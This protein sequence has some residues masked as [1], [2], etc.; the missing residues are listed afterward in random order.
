MNLTIRTA[1]WYQDLL[2]QPEE[3]DGYCAALSQA[4]A[5]SVRELIASLSAPPRAVW[6]THA[7]GRLPGLGLAIHQATPEGTAV[8]V[9]PTGAAAHAAAAL[10]PRWLSGD[11]P[12]THLDA[13]LPYPPV[14]M[15]EH[16]PAESPKANPAR[17]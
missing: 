9:L 4:G 11:L 10:V 12:R 8:E 16:K 2:L 1:H 6:L 7:A 3:L 15:R 5:E 17:G 13:T 14:T